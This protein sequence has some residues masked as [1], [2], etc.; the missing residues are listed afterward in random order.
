ML[1]DVSHKTT[2]TYSQPVSLAQHL[3]H[4]T[5]RLAP[6]QTTHRTALSVV[7]M[8]TFAT[9]GTDYFGNPTTFLSIEEFHS[10]LTI[11]TRSRIEVTKPPPPEPETTMPWETVFAAMAADRSDE[12]LDA[13]QHAFV[14]PNTVASADLKAFT[15]PSFAPGTPVLAGARDLTR[16]IFEEFAYD[17]A[18]TTVT[19]PVDDVF[20]MRRG[21]CQD[22]AHLELAC[23][24]SH[25]LAARYVS[26]YLLT[27]P[28]DGQPR[29]IGADASHAWLSIWCPGQGWVDLDPT[30]NL[31][32]QDEHITLAWGRDYSDVSPIN[33]VIFGGGDHTIHVAVDVV[34]R[35]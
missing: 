11:Q 17:P 35:N 7:P 13:I 12:G 26:G 20:R 27:Q 4:M 25:G 34:P 30:N 18:A 19:T 32:P 9:S 23:L 33:G 14:S 2:Y 5:P 24:R 10:E 1:F 6:G 28:P 8:P 15:R 22:F 16:R 31:L 21:V 29:L 3:L